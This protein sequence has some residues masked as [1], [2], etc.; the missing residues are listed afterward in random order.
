MCANVDFKLDLRINCT[1]FKIE[2]VPAHTADVNMLLP[3]TTI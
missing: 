1:K 3:P 2:T